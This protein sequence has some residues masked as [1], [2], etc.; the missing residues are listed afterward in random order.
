MSF[1]GLVVFGLALAVAAGMPG[2]SI[3]ALVTRVMSRA[4]AAVAIATR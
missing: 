2:P 3:A 4:D 1:S